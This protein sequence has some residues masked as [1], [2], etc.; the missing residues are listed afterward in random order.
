MPGPG[1]VVGVWWGQ[2]YRDDDAGVLRVDPKPVSAEVTAMRRRSLRGVLWEDNQTPFS[3]ASQA[4][5]LVAPPNV[6]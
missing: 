2:V 4:Q 6:S 1:L 3:F 5:D